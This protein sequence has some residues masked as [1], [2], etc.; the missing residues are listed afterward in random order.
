MRAEFEWKKVSFCHR[1]AS[2]RN[3]SRSAG[4]TVVESPCLTPARLP[5]CDDADVDCDDD[6]LMATNPQTKLRLC[7]ILASRR[8]A[9]YAPNPGETTCD[10][11]LND[12]A[13]WRNVPAAVWNY[14]LGGY[15]VLKEWLSY[16][17]QRILNRP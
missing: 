6:V 2:S 3:R 15:Q 16:R 1:S 8:P 4:S 7:H 17:E 11:Y 10:I 9:R 12:R 13:Y 14:Q 5:R